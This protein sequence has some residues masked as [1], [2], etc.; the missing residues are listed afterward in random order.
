MRKQELKEKLIEKNI[1]DFCYNLEGKGRTDE[2]FCLEF[3]NGVWHVY[4]SERG[5][6][7]TDCMF[8]TE[9][10]ACQYLYEKL[11]N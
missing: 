8:K 9:D 4:Y 3:I 6:K 1:S 5:V 2:R 11:I 10:E 7:T